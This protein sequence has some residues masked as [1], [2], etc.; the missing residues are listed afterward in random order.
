MA[1]EKIS[2]LT[3][4]TLPLTGSEQIPLALSG[5]NYQVTVT[6]LFDAPTFVSP[7]LGTPVSGILTHATGLPLTTGVTGNLPVTNLNSGTSASSTTFWRGDGTW[8][9][10]ASSMNY[11]ETLTASTSATLGDSVAFTTYSG[12]SSY[13][14]VFANMIPGTGSEYLQFEVYSSGF[15]STTYLANYQTITSS[16]AVSGALTTNIPLTSNSI[17]TAA[18]GFNGFIRV[19]NP[20]QTTAPKV[21]YG[22]GGYNISS[23]YEQVTYGGFW[24]GNGAITGFQVLFAS[25]NITSGTIKVYGIT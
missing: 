12:Y 14:L 15:Q 16:T 9:E 23:A 18:P 21:W 1:N 25:G 10:P 22:M 11:L 3:A 13:E 5:N 2:Q 6:G 4:A 24:N 8:V 17:T 19:S 7:T 20:S